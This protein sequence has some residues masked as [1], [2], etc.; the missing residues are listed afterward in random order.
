[1]TKAFSSPADVIVDPSIT[2]TALNRNGINARAA[3]KNLHCCTIG[4]QL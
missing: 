1:M 2:K 4:P 3:R